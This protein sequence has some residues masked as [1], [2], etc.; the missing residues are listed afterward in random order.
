MSDFK[1]IK[2]RRVLRPDMSTPCII[3]V[4]HKPHPSGYVYIASRD[5]SGEYHRLHRVVWFDRK[6]PETIPPGH[7]L[8]HA[9]GVRA[10]CNLKHLRVLERSDHVRI[11]NRANRLERMEELYSLWE[12][13][14]RPGCAEFARLINGSNSTTSRYI[15]IWKAEEADFEAWKAEREFQALA[16]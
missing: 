10:C 14:G 11:T 12:F 7:E 13:A 2:W 4:S 6:G 15:R 8:D 9:C 16:A 1:K 5:G 3:P